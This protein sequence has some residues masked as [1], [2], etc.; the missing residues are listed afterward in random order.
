MHNV[1]VTLDNGMT[2]ETTNKTITAEE[3]V[4]FPMNL[5]QK[6][7]TTANVCALINGEENAYD[8]IAFVEGENKSYK[9]SLEL[10]Y[11]EEVESVSSVEE[12]EEIITY[13]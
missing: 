7:S 11:F 2:F 4:V 6:T 13:R 1:I 9:V 10:I 3:E 5:G 8:N 12:E